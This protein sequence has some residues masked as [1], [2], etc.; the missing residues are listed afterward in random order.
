MYFRNKYQTDLIRPKHLTIGQ[1]V[2]FLFTYG[3]CKGSVKPIMAKVLRFY[4][5]DRISISYELNGRIKRKQVTGG[6]LRLPGT[7]PFPSSL[8]ALSP[9]PSPELPT[10][11]ST[12]QMPPECNPEPLAPL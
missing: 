9:D 10:E 4:E 11:S 1:D 3:K 12:S 7:Y 8:R 2:I 6:R 5:D